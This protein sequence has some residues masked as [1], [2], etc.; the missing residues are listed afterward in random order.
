[1]DEN[2]VHRDICAGSITL[3]EGQKRILEKWAWT[4]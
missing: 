4:P 1:M 3:A 2:T